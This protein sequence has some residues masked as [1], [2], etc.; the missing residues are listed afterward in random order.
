[1]VFYLGVPVMPAAAPLPLL[2][3]GL[4]RI[5]REPGVGGAAITV[6]AALLIAAA[7][8]P[9]TLFH[10]SAGAGLYFLC[11]LAGAR[12]GRRRGGRERRARRRRR[13]RPGCP[14]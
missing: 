13:R 3:L 8:H 2:L 4:R 9:E 6:A 12:P 14:P 10:A 11:E 5:A 7:G 1:M